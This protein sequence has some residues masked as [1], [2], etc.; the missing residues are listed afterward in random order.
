[1]MD[2]FNSCSN[3]KLWNSFDDQW[4]LRA[5]VARE[6]RKKTPNQT[7]RTMIERAILTNGWWESTEEATLMISMAVDN[8]QTGFKQ[9]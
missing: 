9:V 8:R 7:W 3:W 2:T 1:M 5:P 4:R 6:A